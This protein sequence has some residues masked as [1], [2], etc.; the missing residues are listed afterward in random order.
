[1]LV[2]RENACRN[3]VPDRTEIRRRTRD[4]DRSLVRPHRAQEN[5]DE[6]RLAGSVS[7]EKGMHLT[8]HEVQIDGAQRLRRAERL[9]HGPGPNGRRPTV[10]RHR[11]P[12]AIVGH[13]V[14]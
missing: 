3:G 9:G 5:L 8:W 11:I 14:G 1:M 2:N 4:L 6:R 7:A 12:F 13:L 10:L